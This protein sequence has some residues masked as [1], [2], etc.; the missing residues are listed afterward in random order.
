MFTIT[1]TAWV[2]YSTPSSIRNR[3]SLCVVAKKNVYV[4]LYSN[5]IGTDVRYTYLFSLRIPCSC[6]NLS[7]V[8]KLRGRTHMH[9][10]QM[11][12]TIR[13]IYYGRHITTII[14]NVYTCSIG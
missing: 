8:I 14:D 1:R 4:S 13:R 2:A 12:L 10:L 5:Q 7:S 11:K 3:L 6:N 9:A